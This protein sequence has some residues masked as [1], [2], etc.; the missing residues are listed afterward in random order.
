MISFILNNKNNFGNACKSMGVRN[1]V[2][3]YF[4]ENKK[5]LDERTFSSKYN[6]LNYLFIYFL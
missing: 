4:S 5:A 2:T 1:L 6:Y 3:S